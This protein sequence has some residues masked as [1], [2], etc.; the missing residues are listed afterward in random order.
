[1]NPTPAP[2][3]WRFV[4]LCEIPEIG[5]LPGDIVSH[6]AGRQIRLTRRLPVNS[7]LLLN[8]VLSDQLA[9][10]DETIGPDSAVLDLF[11]R[12]DLRRDDDPPAAPSIRV[13]R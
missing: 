4:A 3:P 10:I 1:M 13:L 11:D 6:T 9:E 5:A 7:G 8:L 2:K 12:I